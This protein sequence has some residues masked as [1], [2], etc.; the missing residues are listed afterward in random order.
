MHDS[1]A[2]PDRPTCTLGERSTPERSGDLVTLMPLRCLNG[3]N[4]E[5][6]FQHDAESW[7]HLRQHNRAE[8]ALVFP[9]CG[10]SV[11]LRTSKLGTR[12]FAHKPGANCSSQPESQEHVLA[13]S[14]IAVAA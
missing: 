5:L 3:E 7:E 8:G 2:P 13:K 11:S 10:A 1:Y 14:I 9:C 6:A 4:D 12:Y